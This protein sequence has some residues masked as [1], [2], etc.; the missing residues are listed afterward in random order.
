MAATGRRRHLLVLDIN[1][2]LLD[3][4][5][6]GKQGPGRPYDAKVNK[7]SVYKR[8]FCDEFL[9]FCL[10]HFVVG[11]W[12]SAQKNNVYAFVEYIFKEAKE[13]LAFVWHQ[14]H[15]TNT[16]FRHPDDHHVPVFL[17]ELWKLWEK[18]EP[19]LPW[20][21]GDYDPL[22]TLLIDDSPSKAMKN[23][24]YTAIFPKTYKATDPNDNYLG[25]ELRIYLQGLLQMTDVQAYVQENPFGERSIAIGDPKWSKILL[26]FRVEDKR[27]PS[28]GG[29][30]V[31]T[32]HTTVPKNPFSPLA[33]AGSQCYLS[34]IGKQKLL[35]ALG[36]EE[37]EHEKNLKGEGG[38]N[39]QSA[40]GKLSLQEAP[41]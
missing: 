28:V 10:D 2:L 41:A 22:N 16:G 9:R 12:S 19:N 32:G 7:F 8:P 15:C 40:L 38:N 21:A 4:Y 3:T 6:R 13:K 34:K 18:I 29:H 20:E 23:P 5:R 11:V 39:L 25:A 26:S 14:D 27:V 24:S 30:L 37:E 1:G 31:S 33:G 35:E 17:K 36:Y